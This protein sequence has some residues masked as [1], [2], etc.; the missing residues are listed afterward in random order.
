[1]TEQERR[2][3]ERLK[4]KFVVSYHSLE[5]PSATFDISQIKDISLGGMRFVTSR[6]YQAD[7]V[8]AIE[9]QT[10]FVRER[11]SLQAKVLESKEVVADLIYD[12]RVI[13]SELDDEAKH[14]LTRTI[15]I[16]LKK[17]KEK[18]EE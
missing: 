17:D 11:L 4:R 10:P 18:K 5:D 3:F 9:L 14:Y 8:L 1:M 16:F 12:T 13:F 15:E 7:T 6:G 2:Q